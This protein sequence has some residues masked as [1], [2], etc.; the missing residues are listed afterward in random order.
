MN[1][2]I[3]I[4]I[5]II[6]LLCSMITISDNIQKDNF[7]SKGSIL[8]V[9]GTGTG[10]YTTIQ[11]AIDYASSG[12]TVFVYN[13]T[14]FENVVV[15]KKINLI[16]E[17]R[18]NTIIDGKEIDHA[19][20]VSVDFVNIC[21]FTIKNTSLPHSGV[22]ISSNDTSIF[23]NIL[24]SNSKAMNMIT[25]NNCNFFNNILFN[26]F[27]QDISIHESNSNSFKNNLM[28]NLL[29]YQCSQITIEN[30][31]FLDNSNSYKG[32]EIR[33][34][35]DC[36]INN[37]SFL[38]DGIA[39][40]GNNRL[41]WTSHKIENNIVNNSPIYFM[42]NTNGGMVPSDAG[43]VILANCSDMTIQGLN[44]TNLGLAIQLGHSNN[45]NITNNF[46]SNNSGGIILKWSLNNLI[47]DNKIIQ[48]DGFAYYSLASYSNTISKNFISENEE[49]ISFHQSD[50][51][52]I[53]N[54]TITE[55]GVRAIKIYFSCNNEILDNNIFNNNI[56]VNID[57]S[58]YNNIIYHNNLFNNS[59]H[60][61]DT[62]TN[63]WDN[64]YPSGGNYWDDYTDIDA[65]GDGI[66]DTPYDIQGGN[67]QDRYPLGYFHPVADFTYSPILPDVDELVYFNSTSFDPDGSIVNYTWYFGDSISYEINPTHQYDDNG[68]Y[69]VMLDVTDN[70]GRVDTVAKM[71]PVDFQ[72]MPIS[73]VKTGWNFISAPYNHS[74][75]T[76]EF[77]I[78]HEEYYYN[79]THATTA[80]NPTNNPLINQYLFGWNRSIQTYTFERN[81]E[82]GYGYWMYAHQPCELWNQYDPIPPDTYVTNLELGWNII[83]IPDNQ[84]VNKTD[85]L[86]NNV[87]W[88]TAVSN[89]WVSGYVFGWNEIGQSY[90]FSDVFEPGQAYW[91]YAYQQCVLKR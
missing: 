75:D 43:Q 6:L 27:F 76:H 56:G 41:H 74:Q 78:K 65:N 53:N 19:I 3:I 40:N 4:I 49:G 7:D 52:I 15:N 9:G 34:S 79:W 84:L 1:K 5:I 8:Y 62:E 48:S 77:L 24:T 2:K 81:L 11:S 70:E 12:D 46:L 25:S 30:N 47:T 45:N 57:L 23:D 59:I 63:I 64:G 44:L 16:G 39:I 88:N 90:V 82:P 80:I 86:V 89:S 33:Y 55:S 32:I 87:D 10:N 21:S 91:M 29:T 20:R 66:G 73:T 42:K 68:I 50:Y 61:Y 69:P 14:Y 13:G 71:V 83:S 28:N 17:H 51:N 58:S 31:T 37:N 60:A 22:Y 54:N 18:N 67:N 36:Y 38:T 26:N 72:M 85:L 35:L